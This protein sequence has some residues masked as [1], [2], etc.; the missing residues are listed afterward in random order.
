MKIL[1]FIQTLPRG[2]ARSVVKLIGMLEE[3]PFLNGVDVSDA[4]HEQVVLRIPGT[5]R[6]T[7][8][9]FRHRQTLLHNYESRRCHSLLR[10]IFI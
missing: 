10:Y 2:G 3:R 7:G 8:S 1:T 4:G 6:V 5:D 9:S